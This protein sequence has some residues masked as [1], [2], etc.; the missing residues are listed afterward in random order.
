[1][2]SPLFDEIYDETMAWVKDLV[3]GIPKKVTCRKPGTPGFEPPPPRPF[4]EIAGIIP[5]HQDT[6]LRRV[7][8]EGSEKPTNG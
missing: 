8:T 5:I 7:R 4:G 3:P 6:Y 2:S 1:M